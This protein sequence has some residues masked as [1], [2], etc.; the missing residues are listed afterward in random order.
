LLSKPR[1]RWKLIRAEL[2]RIGEKYGD[3]RRTAF[4]AGEELEYDPEAY[5]VHED[6]T[7]IVSRDGWVKRVREVKDP[8][9]TRLREGDAIFQML[10]ASTRDRVAFFSSFGGLYVLPVNDIPATTG[11]GEPI[12]SLVKLADN[13]KLTAVYV[14]PG[15]K[16]QSEATKGQQELFMTPTAREGESYL[17]S[18]SRGFGFRFTPDLSETTRAGRKVARVSSGDAV[19]AVVSIRGKQVICAAARGKMLRFPLSEVAELSGA[20]KGVYLMRPGGADDRI[21][22]AVAPAKGNAV[23]VVTTEGTDRKIPVEDVP[24]GKR[25]GKGLKV[26]KRGQIAAIRAEE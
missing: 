26:V 24:V 16:R 20:G 21:V 3:K 25:A 23:I 2:E 10:V 1:E 19:V 8:A 4:A 6:T 9:S 11:Y 22:G 15:G 13:E 12:Q 18:T 14:V 7:V 17:L 5:I